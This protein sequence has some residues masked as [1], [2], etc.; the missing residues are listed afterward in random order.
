MRMWKAALF[1]ATLVVGGLASSRALA[2]GCYNC[3]SGSANGCNQC[4][5]GTSDTGDKRKECEKRGCKIT[6]TSSC[7]SAANVKVCA[8]DTHEAP[9][10]VIAWCA[11]Q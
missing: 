8:L 5:Y 7:S 11:P 6:G 1:A 4:R 9:T 10:A 2:D 3:G